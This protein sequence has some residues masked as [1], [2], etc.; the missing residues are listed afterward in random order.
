MSTTEAAAQPLRTQLEIDDE[1]V[2]T[3]R[4][5]DGSARPFILDHDSVAELAAHVD[6]LEKNH[7]VK[8]VVITSNHPSVFCAGA[9]VSLIEN[10]KTAEDAEEAVSG[11][12]RLF[13]RIDRLHA[14]VVAAIHGVCVGGG[15]ELTL[16][17]DLRVVSD[18]GRTRLGLPEVKL[19]IL[20]AWGGTTRLPEIVGLKTALPLLLTGRLLSSR[21]VVKCGLAAEAVPARA[22][23]ARA[24][25]RALALHTGRAAHHHGHDDHGDGHQEKPRHRN[26]GLLD[27]GIEEIPALRNAFLNAAAGRVRKETHGHYPAPKRIL[28]VLQ[29]GFGKSRDVRLALERGAFAELITGDVAKKL[30]SIFTRNKD[31]VRGAPYDVKVDAPRI[32]RVA[33]IG[34]GVMGAGIASALLA[35]GLDVRLVDPFPE[36]LTKGRRLI[37]KDIDKRVR[38]RRM[39]R[40]EA[41]RT[42]AR[43]ALA[44][45][46]R[47]LR[48]ADLVI[49]AV[50]EVP[51]IKQEALEGIAAA[52]R[53]GTLVT[54][55]TS[56]LSVSELARHVN[57]P[58]LFAGLHF[59]N[60]PQKMPLV[61]VVRAEATT[62]ATLA[63][64]A[65]FTRSL[66]KT[67]VVCADRPAFAVNRLLA[68]YMLEAFDLVMNGAPIARVDKAAREFGLP[69][70]PFELMDTVGL[71]VVDHVCRY[72][73][74]FP[75]LGIEAPA[76]LSAMVQRGRL[77][78]KN[79]RG[80]YRHGKR[81]RRADS[82][83]SIRSLDR[84]NGSNQLEGI[85]EVDIRKRLL[86]ALAREAR[87][88]LDEG[89]VASRDDLDLA[90]IF[91][92]GFPPWTGGIG[93][94][95]EAGGAEDVR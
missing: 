82:V 64:L 35:R 81:R 4:L 53:P 32:R 80:F 67:P 24:R 52:V 45:D 42:L 49:E 79:G 72:L 94:W 10:L 93:S 14:P 91:G 47:G 48:S 51:E 76:A 56:S 28:D 87:L 95:L 84:P 74:G 8:A 3:I 19:G 59:F 5:G 71:D 37:E 11:G 12:Q 25:E 39:D 38:R 7:D 22:L 36:A 62:D 75:E 40:H 92:M 34:A 17:C 30:I 90:S 78:K 50:P 27:Y 16:A 66:D 54:T 43:L 9:E 33:V 29:H 68:P 69:M 6:V 55:N 60:P 61:E 58:E 85:V 44:L 31:A 73:A 26:V 89:V 41:R 23:V 70:G 2:A 83:G 63:R 15:L 21:A 65:A 20:P 77:G 13:D 1:G 57:E 46:M 18:D 86:G 88:V